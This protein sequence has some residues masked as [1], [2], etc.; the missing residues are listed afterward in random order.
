MRK[1]NNNEIEKLTFRLND[2]EDENTKLKELLKQNG[3]DLK[4]KNIK[5][6][7]KILFKIIKKTK[8][9]IKLGKIFFF[10]IVF[11]LIYFFS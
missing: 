10:D 2:I 9:M 6:K 11:Y 8:M 1:T 4:D 7:K 5:K 3:N